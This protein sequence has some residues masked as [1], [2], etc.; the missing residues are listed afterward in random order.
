MSSTNQFGDGPWSDVDQDS[1]ATPGAAFVPTS[2]E[3]SSATE[4]LSNNDTRQTAQIEWNSPA[5]QLTVNSYTV[6][7]RSCSTTGYS[8][9]S[10][11][12]TRTT[13]D[14]NATSYVIP[15]TSLRDGLHYQ[16]RVRANGSSANGG[17]SQYVESEVIYLVAIDDN[18]TS[19][20]RDR[21]H[22]DRHRTLLE[23][24]AGPQSR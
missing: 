24:V 4:T 12:N 14:G 10:Y 18:G 2:I 22:G 16:A 3:M 13:A 7:W 19:S 5:S 11:G 20:D 1:T 21:R 17:S 9:G 6:Q 23:E 15:V 8:C